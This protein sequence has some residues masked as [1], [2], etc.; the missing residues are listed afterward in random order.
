MEAT[1][2]EADLA[3]TYQ[4]SLDY[5]ASLAPRGWRLGLDRMAEFA[6]RADIRTDGVTP[7][8]IHVA[9]TN[10]KGSVTA[11]LQSLLVAHG[12]RTG[13]FFSPYVYDPRERI[14]FGHEMISEEDFA[15]I[16]TELRPI[17]ESF[18]DT[19]YDGITEFEFKT[20]VGFR[21]FQEMSCQFVA[22]EVGLG[23][24]LDATNIVQTASGI[25]VSI[26]L[27]HVAILGHTLQEIAH[28]KAGIMKGQPIAVGELPKEAAQE[29]D[30]QGGRVGS[31]LSTIGR[32]FWIKDIDW[33]G[34]KGSAIVTPL[35]EYAWIEPGIKGVRQLHNAALAIR[36]MELA[37]HG[38]LDPDLVRIAIEETR[39]PGRFEVR[40]GTPN[41]ILDGAH[42]AE[43]AAVLR[44]SLHQEFPDRQFT[45]ITNMV[46]GHEPEPF[47]RQFEGLLERIIVAPIDFHRATPVTEMVAKLRS[48]FPELEIMGTD[49]AI[50][51]IELARTQTSDV[52]VTGSY[53]LVGDIGRT[54]AG[55]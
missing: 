49:S 46:G 35:E 51:A 38:R 53:Y 54:L 20:A 45:L 19:E 32:N 15:R 50:R 42:N 43:A 55:C 18:S 36:G 52:L 22:L 26:G 30:E 12:Y 8:Y 17:A 41:W 23:G 11:Y 25:I 28:E 31:I 9:G 4:E 21:Y 37:T 44:D 6:R 10:G 1:T 33:D 39:A 13:A 40:A 3:M 7:K 24:R 5:I 34:E 48:I 29:V 47:Y 27:D 2:R 16:T 14:Q